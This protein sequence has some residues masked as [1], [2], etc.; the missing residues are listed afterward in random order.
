M[1]QDNKIIKSFIAEGII[2]AALAALIMDKS[3]DIGLIA[4]TAFFASLQAKENASKLGISRIIE[5]DHALYEVKPDGSD[6]LIKV[7]PKFTKTI[8]KTFKLD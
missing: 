8:P 5:K 4:S 3:S 7:L 1:E 6:T 2:S